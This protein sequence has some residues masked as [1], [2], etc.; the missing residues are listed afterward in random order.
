MDRN[1]VKQSP[2]V[3]T[4]QELRVLEATL[5]N[6]KEEHWKCRKCEK[7]MKAEP[8]KNNK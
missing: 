6:K 8:A 4:A 2:A 3:W 5:V 1:V 7:D